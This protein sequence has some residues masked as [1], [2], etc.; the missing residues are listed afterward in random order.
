M[1]LFLGKINVTKKEAKE[2][3]LFLKERAIA[4]DDEAYSFWGQWEMCGHTI[5]HMNEGDIH[6][7]IYIDDVDLNASL[8]NPTF[9][10]MER[11]NHE[12]LEWQLNRVL[13]QADVE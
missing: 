11:Y 2:F 12:F 8:V 5:R 7:P 13:N 6:V 10:L 1:D 9:I 3:K 4:S